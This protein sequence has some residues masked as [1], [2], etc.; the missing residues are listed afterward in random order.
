M[1]SSGIHPHT[2]SRWHIGLRS[3]ELAKKVSVVWNLLS[4]PSQSR[5]YEDEPS[6]S[7][8]ERCVEILSGSGRG[9]YAQLPI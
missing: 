5:S 2:G 6:F 3:L 9:N 4:Q 7:F 8:I 1:G